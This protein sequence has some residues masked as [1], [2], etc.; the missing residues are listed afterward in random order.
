MT[1]KSELLAQLKQAVLEGKEEATNLTREAVNA[2]IKPDS[3]I[4][5]GLI[6]GI[7]EA[8]E[9]WKK[10]VYFWPEVVM[11]TDTFQS[12]MEV[13]KP[14]LSTGAVGAAGK[15]IIGTVA[16]DVHNLGKMIVISMLQCANF[17]VTD[18]GE[19]V[20]TATFIAKAKELKPDIVGVACYM[21]T[22]MLEMKNVI[23]SL[24]ENGLMNRVKVII[25]GIPTSQEF[26]SEIG[27]H[28]WGKDAID[29]VEKCRQLM[30]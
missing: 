12:V 20:P 24:K 3:I 11:S 13:L 15:I 27:A 14:Y 5:E 18:L 19:D 10:N 1:N 30:R 21:T 25:G 2:G 16:G 26:A 9:L 8:G 4:N 6:P 23:K 28:A 17:S 29:A 22:T 7:K